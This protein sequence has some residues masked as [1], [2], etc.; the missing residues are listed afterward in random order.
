MKVSSYTSSHTLYTHSGAQW[1]PVS[2]PDKNPDVLWN[3]IHVILFPGI[4]L[5]SESSEWAFMLRIS[6]GESVFARL[7]KHMF[8]GLHL[9]QG[10]RLSSTDCMLLLLSDWSHTWDYTCVDDTC[11]YW[12]EKETNKETNSVYLWLIQIFAIGGYVR[13]FLCEARHWSA[14]LL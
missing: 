5:L 1:G 11:K 10:F 7:L 2:Y 9:T 4:S 13:P 12:K 3:P 6:P 8:R 14:L